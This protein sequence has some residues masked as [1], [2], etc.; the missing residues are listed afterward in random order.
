MHPSAKVGNVH[1]AHPTSVVI[2]AGVVIEDDV[3]IWQNVTLGAID[4]G[5]GGYPVV[6]RGA[7]LFASSTALGRIEIGADAVIGAHSLVL[8]DVPAGATAVG[9]PARIIRA[10]N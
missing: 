10:S 1:F 8:D 9:Q 7:K 6:R 3:M 5:S 4:V 2:G